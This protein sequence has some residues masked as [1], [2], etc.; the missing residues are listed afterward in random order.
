MIKV[1]EMTASNDRTRYMGNR[2]TKNTASKTANQQVASSITNSN[3]DFTLHYF[4]SEEGEEAIVSTTL[5]MGRASATIYKTKD[6]SLENPVYKVIMWDEAGNETERM[7]DLSKVNIKD[8]D[9]L[10]MLAYTTYL[11]ETGSD[12]NAV[13]KMTLANS[14]QYQSEEEVYKHVLDKQNWLDIIG[15]AMQI[16]GDAGNWYGYLE[17]KKLIDILS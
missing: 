13:G 9:T 3:T 2:T 15:N 14:L 11:S 7:V 4:D 12:Q 10:D 8:C 6:F 5:G 1:K 16:Q 17:F